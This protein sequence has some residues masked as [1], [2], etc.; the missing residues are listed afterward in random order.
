MWVLWKSSSALTTEPPLQLQGVILNA[1][2]LAFKLFPLI[3]S[4]DLKK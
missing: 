2:A 1:L 3:S 4:I